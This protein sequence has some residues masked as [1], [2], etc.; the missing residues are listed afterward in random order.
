MRRFRKL[1]ALP[2][3]TGSIRPG[4]SVQLHG[5][6]ETPMELDA[7]A[8]NHGRS[9][10]DEDEE[11]EDDDQEDADIRDMVAALMLLTVDRSGTEVVE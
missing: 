9:M 1:A 7:Q 8:D 3:F 10:D 11:E 4:V 6:T 2:G 5:G